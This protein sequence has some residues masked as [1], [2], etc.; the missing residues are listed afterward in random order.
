MPGSPP[1]PDQHGFAPMLL[2]MGSSQPLCNG[3][4]CKPRV[5]EARA[6]ARCPPFPT[7]VFIPPCQWG[8]DF[9]PPSQGF[10]TLCPLLTS[11]AS[12]L[13]SADPDPGK[14][15]GFAGSWAR[16]HRHHGLDPADAQLSQ[17]WGVGWGVTVWGWHVGV[18]WNP[19]GG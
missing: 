10:K 7:G 13:L 19:P 1:V 12:F 3:A 18:Q 2:G 14:Q 17:V 11:S 4:V 15:L 9:A 5:Q 6:A 8:G 16:E